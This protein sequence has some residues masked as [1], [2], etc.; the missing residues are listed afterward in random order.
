M[1]SY[2]MY[3]FSNLWSSFIYF[4]FKYLHA[5]HIQRITYKQRD[6]ISH[7]LM[8]HITTGISRVKVK[9]C[10]DVLKYGQIENS[11]SL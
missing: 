1:Q 10:V 5:I 3:F 7:T 6:Q 4:S 8:L 9:Y 11:F 2:I